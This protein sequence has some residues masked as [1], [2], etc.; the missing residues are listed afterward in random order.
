MRKPLAIVALVA[1]VGAAAWVVLPG[2]LGRSVA[3][4]ASADVGVPFSLGDMSFNPFAGRATLSDVVLESE[5]PFVSP[6]AVRVDKI[7]ATFEASTVLSP[8][9]VVNEVVVSGVDVRIEQRGTRINIREL[10]A[11]MEAYLADA[12]TSSQARVFVHE[13]RIVG[14]RGKLVTDAGERDFDIRDV[15]LRDLGSE[16]SGTPVHVLAGN[17]VEPLLVQALE[18][19]G[20]SAGG[21]RGRIGR[22]FGRD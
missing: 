12:D 4:S 18:D 22:L 21:L 2:L 8:F 9:I 1:V 19:A 6:H 17:V 20:L 11:R 14:A 10:A 3:T 16:S 5:D 7:E 13:F 15:V